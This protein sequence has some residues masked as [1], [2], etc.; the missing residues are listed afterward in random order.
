MFGDKLHFENAMIESPLE[1]TNFTKNF[2]WEEMKC[3][4]GCG[5]ANME[6]NFMDLLQQLRDKVGLLK[7]SSGF[8]CEEYNKL[9]SSTGSDGP[10]TSGKAAD[11]LCSGQLAIRV[12][13][14]AYSLGFTGFGFSQKGNHNERFVH[15]D[16]LLAGQTKGPRPWPWTY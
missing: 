2:S 16:T 8:R 13:G 10:H 1:G 11:I 7:I 14:E 15:L 3:K 4:C 12:F 9:V 5:K 6:M